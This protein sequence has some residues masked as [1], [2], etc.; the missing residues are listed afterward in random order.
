MTYKINPRTDKP[1][2]AMLT[3]G[4]RNFL[5]DASGYASS[6]QSD[7]YGAIVRG[8][9]NTFQDFNLLVEELPDDKRREIFD[10]EHGMSDDRELLEALM[11]T[12]AFIYDGVGGVPKFEYILESGV[13]KGEHGLHIGQEKP[14]VDVELRVKH[15]QPNAGD[16]IEVGERLQSREIGD[17]SRFELATFFHHMILCDPEFDDRVEMLIEDLQ[18]RDTAE[19]TA[20]ENLNYSNLA[21]DDESRQDG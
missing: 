7:Y 18:N 15:R 5:R 2:N 19:S 14:P 6:T 16:L 9:W 4:H 3:D 17:L 12:I 10:V 8:V 1:Q 20:W 11:N 21:E 13:A